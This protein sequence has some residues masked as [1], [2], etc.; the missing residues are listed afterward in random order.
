MQIKTT[1]RYNCTPIRKA[2]IKPNDNIQCWLRYRETGSLSY[3]AGECNGTASG[4]VWQYLQELNM[5]LPYSLAIV[6]LSIHPRKMKT[7]VLIKTCM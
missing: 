6:L 3:I 2:K 5:Q 4:K 7:Y 1:M